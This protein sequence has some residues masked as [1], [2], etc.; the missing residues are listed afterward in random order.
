MK[1]T[2]LSRQAGTRTRLRKQRNILIV[3]LIASLSLIAWLIFGNSNPEQD[4]TPQN[5]AIQNSIQ[6]H[7]EFHNSRMEELQQNEANLQK[8]VLSF[9]EEAHK[10]L[11]NASS[12]REQVRILA[13]RTQVNPITQSDT[14]Q[15]LISCDSLQDQV[16]ELISAEQYKDSI[17]NKQVMVYED[18]IT[19]KDST[20]SVWCEDYTCLRAQTDT[21][22][23]LNEKLNAAYNKTVRQIR[24]AKRWNRIT[25]GLA[26]V[27]GAGFTIREL[28]RR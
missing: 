8:Q 9:K 15:K 13:N 24:R 17:V 18:L 27:L 19:A 7:D 22:L 6:A 21:L 5:N 28:Y 10:A 14:I 1:R 11:D 25:S 2:S 3:A 20:I 12:L 23:Q 4:F 26:L 16:S